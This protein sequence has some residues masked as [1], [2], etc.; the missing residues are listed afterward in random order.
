VM[1]APHPEPSAD[2]DVQRLFFDVVARSVDTSA[3]PGEQFTV[4]WN[5][6]DAE[7]WHVIVANGSTRAEPGRAPAADITFETKWADWIAV[8][9]GAADPKRLLLQ[10]RLRFRGS[11]LR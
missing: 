11:P 2:P 3:A 8:S 10:R 5:F 7:P 6:E 9:K 4:Q 1:G